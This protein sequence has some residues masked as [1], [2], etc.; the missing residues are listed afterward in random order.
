LRRLLTTE[1]AP[2]EI[3]AIRQLLALAF[4][5][6]EDERF[7]EHDWEH[8]LGGMHFVLDLDGV[9]VGHASVVERELQIDGRA[10]RTGYVEAVG[11]APD[12]QGAGFGSQVMTDVNAWIT[13]RFELGAL[14]TGRH[15][16][17]ERL[18]WRTWAGPTSVRTVEGTQRTP[19][20]DGDILVLETPSSP[21]LD[22]GAAISCEW[23]PGDVW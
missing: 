19:D 2:E 15:R 16:F 9:I 4:G 22:L 5:P 8:A 7:G 14:G 23:R 17:Y 11:V 1:L 21:P 3:T 10:L 6:E 20:E 13:E 18:G 12:R